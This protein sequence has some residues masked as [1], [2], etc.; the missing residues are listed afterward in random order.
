[1]SDLTKLLQEKIEQALEM[2][3][4]QTGVWHLLRLRDTV[5][6]MYEKE[7]ITDAEYAVVYKGIEDGI[8]ILE[9]SLK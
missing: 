6:E 4:A 5:N 1:M 9:K 8:Y 3:Q 2:E 7:T